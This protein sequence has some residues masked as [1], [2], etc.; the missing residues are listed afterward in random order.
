M[1]LT[2]L[3]INRPSLIIV[4]FSIFTLVGIIGFKN[5]SYE[6][7]PDFNQPV[8][9]IKTAYPG[10]NPDEVEFSVS[11][12]I[13]KALSH[14]EGVDYLLTKSLANASVVIAHLNYGVDLDNAMRDA[15]RYIDNIRHELPTEV[16]NPVMSKV[17]P[18]DLPM[19]SA[20]LT[21]NLEPKVFYRH[22]EDEIQ[23]KQHSNGI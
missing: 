6:L 4:L 8:V 9:V 11:Q 22:L 19:M 13:E 18:N 16:L 14:L 2:R 23:N 20:S 10:A 21:S 5:L 7:M 1:N 12:R 3:A 15:Q 17:S